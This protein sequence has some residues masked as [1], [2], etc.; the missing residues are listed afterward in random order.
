MVDGRWAMEGE[1][2]KRAR[3]G[4]LEDEA[5]VHRDANVARQTVF[6]A[7]LVFAA[8]VRHARFVDRLHVALEVTEADVAADRERNGFAAVTVADAAVTGRA[9]RGQEVRG[10]RLV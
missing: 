5:D 7:D 2:A 10:A 4:A 6:D 8:G 3:P 1:P 9:A